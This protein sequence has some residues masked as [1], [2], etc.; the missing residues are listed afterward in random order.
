MISEVECAFYYTMGWMQ[1]LIVD[2]PND[3][4]EDIIRS[5]KAMYAKMLEAEQRDKKQKEQK[6]EDR[7]LAEMIDDMRRDK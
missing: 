5:M 4:K 7:P 2:A 3:S 1:R 6:T